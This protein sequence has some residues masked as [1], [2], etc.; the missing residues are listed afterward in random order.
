MKCGGID[1]GER[2]RE[3]VEGQMEKRGKEK[4]LASLLEHLKRMNCHLIGEIGCTTNNCHPAC[5][6]IMGVELT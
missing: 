6:A 3:R 4:G 1:G 2:K 5:D